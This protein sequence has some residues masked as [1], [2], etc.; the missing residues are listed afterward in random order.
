MPPIIMEISKIVEVILS[1]FWL[2]EVF[3]FL[4][5]SLSFFLSCFSFFLSI[6]S[7]FLF[8][9]H[10]LLGSRPAVDMVDNQNGT[11]AFSFSFSLSLLSFFPSFFLYPPQPPIQPQQLHLP[12]PSRM[13]RYIHSKCIPN[14]SPLCSF[15]H[16]S[17]CGC[18]P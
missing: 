4:S 10:F 8:L 16:T 11:F 3:F 17:C 13:G 5:F 2:L 18:G 15:S 14:G 6:F 1:K 9:Q 7:L 12:F